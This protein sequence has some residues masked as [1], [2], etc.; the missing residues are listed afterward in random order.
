MAILIKTYTK[1][2]KAYLE[3]DK[4]GVIKNIYDIK[5][6]KKSKLFKNKKLSFWQKIIKYFKRK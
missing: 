1:S 2:G 5:G 3:C 6:L 4:K